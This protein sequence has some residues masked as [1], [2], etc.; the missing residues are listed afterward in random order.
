MVHVKRA[1]IFLVL[2]AFG[3]AS[4][5]AQAPMTFNAAEREP[6]CA[7][8][9]LGQYSGC[10]SGSRAADNRMLL[11]DVLRACAGAARQCLSTCEVRK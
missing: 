1:V 4:E 5:Q 7:R 2:F 11:G 9:C 3:C 10:A 8:G 6:V